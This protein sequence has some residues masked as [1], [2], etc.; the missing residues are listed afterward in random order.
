MNIPIAEVLIENRRITNW[1]K[2]L[3]S[4]HNV[5]LHL[6]NVWWHEG[7]RMTCWLRGGLEV[8]VSR[9]GGV[10]RYLGFVLK[11]L[12]ISGYPQPRR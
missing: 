12:V 1:D 3:E 5:Q 10:K 6:V 11:N 7:R 9:K 2:T 8:L 4:L